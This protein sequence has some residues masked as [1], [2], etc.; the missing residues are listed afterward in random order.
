MFRIIRRV[1]VI[2][3]NVFREIFRER[4]LYLLGF[5]A[6]ALLLAARL[7][8]ELSAGMACSAARM[9]ST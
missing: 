6:V 2:A 1:S 8:P 3:A 4:A 5:Y 9:S 7:L